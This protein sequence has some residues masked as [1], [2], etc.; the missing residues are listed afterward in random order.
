MHKAI[1]LET[2]QVYAIGRKADC[3]R[4]LT[5][6]FPSFSERQEGQTGATAETSRVLPEPMQIIKEGKS[7]WL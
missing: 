3:Y 2:G 1:G 6:L 7:T 4:E 5:N